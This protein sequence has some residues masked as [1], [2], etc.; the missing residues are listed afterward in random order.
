MDT[1][2][3]QQIPVL[4]HTEKSTY[5]LFKA[6]I[7]Y[8]KLTNCHH[9]QLQDINSVELASELH[10]QPLASI[11]L[12]LGLVRQSSCRGRRRQWLS[13]TQC[14]EECAAQWEEAW[15]ALLYL[16]IWH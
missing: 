11:L 2:L 1:L 8:Y 15:R 14:G 6:C 3:P 12:T 10:Q 5:F 7:Y 9:L 16:L 4:P 13:C